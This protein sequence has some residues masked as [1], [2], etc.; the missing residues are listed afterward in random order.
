[1]RS[2]L[3]AL[4]ACVVFAFSAQA[5]TFRSNKVQK[6]AAHAASGQIKAWNPEQGTLT[7]LVPT[8]VTV[9]T[10]QRFATKQIIQTTTRVFQVEPACPVFEEDVEDTTD[11]LLPGQYVSLTYALKSRG[12]A[13]KDQRVATRI[14]IEKP[15][16]PTNRSALTLPPIVREANALKQELE[17]SDYLRVA[18]FTP[19]QSGKFPPQSQSYYFRVLQMMG[20]KEGTVEEIQ[21][22][23]RQQQELFYFRGDPALGWVDGKEIK[24]EGYYEVTGKK[25]YQNLAGSTKTVFVL[26]PESEA[27][28]KKREAAERGTEAAKRDA[29]AKETEEA[30]VKKQQRIEQAKQRIAKR[31][32][33]L[34][35]KPVTAAPIKPAPTPSDAS[36][37]AAKLRLAK[38]L[39][40]AGKTES[41]NAR[42]EQIIKDY[43]GTEAAEEAK[44]LLGK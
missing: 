8:P 1:M 44:G 6:Q 33:M 23:P 25:T 7:L 39:L 21:V 31:D 38:V 11:I 24:L 22:F 30:R 36:A 42:L 13:F 4:C 29:T 18:R 43:P 2:L 14:V 9:Q 5:Q 15:P 37:A 3:A 19:G 32:A 40:E 34:K 27:A 41:A 26:E 16:Q 35:S 20:P 12:Q 10:N 28:K 17:K